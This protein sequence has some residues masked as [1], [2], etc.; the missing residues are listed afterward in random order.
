[1]RG[2]TWEV[3]DRC[4]GTLTRV[5]TGVVVVENIRTGRTKVVKAGESVLVR[6]RARRR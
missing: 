6:R 2:T 3:V 4:D 1:V 5:H